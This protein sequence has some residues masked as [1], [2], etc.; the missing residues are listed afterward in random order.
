MVM[1]EDLSVDRSWV[2]G[3]PRLMNVGVAMD[4]VNTS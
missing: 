4:N 2:T 3:R 1:V